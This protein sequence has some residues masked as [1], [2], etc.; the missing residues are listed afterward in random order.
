MPDRLH[1]L[2]KYALAQLHVVHS[3][4]TSFLSESMLNHGL[5]CKNGLSAL[6]QT[7]RRTG[8]NPL[9]VR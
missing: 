8:M 9:E 6:S 5:M 3:F 4:I 2:H 1:T 7:R